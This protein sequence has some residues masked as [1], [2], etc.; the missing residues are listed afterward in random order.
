MK[1]KFEFENFEIEIEFDKISEN[2]AIDAII[3]NIESQIEI[4]DFIDSN[5]FAEIIDSNE[6]DDFYIKFISFKSI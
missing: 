5:K 2:D 6:F 4:D 1:T 3:S